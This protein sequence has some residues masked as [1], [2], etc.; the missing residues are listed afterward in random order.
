MK[1]AVLAVQG[2][3]IEHEKQLE[4]LGIECI[5]LRQAADLEK[6]YDGIILPGGESTVQGK[7]LKDLG[8]F[9]LLKEQIANGM[10]VL[11][12][13]AGLILLAEGISNDDRTYLQTLPVVVKRNAYGRQLGSFHIEGE[14][15]G[16]GVVPMEFIRAPYIE[17][18]K[19]D[20]EVLATEGDSNHIVMVQYKNQLAMAFHPELCECTKIHERFVALMLGK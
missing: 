3:F 9:D 1:V 16:I 5:E 10:P 12:T 14:V 6:E 11:A 4:R 18:V 19:D 15:K 7:L 20:V 2:A 17:S 8:M 13:C